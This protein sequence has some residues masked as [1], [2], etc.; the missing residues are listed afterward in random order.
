G[1][2][3]YVLV[4]EVF[5][6]LTSSET[7]HRGAPFYFYGETLA[8]A[9]GLW[10][11]VLAA[12]A[13]GLVRCWRRGGH[14][15]P[16]IALATRGTAA[17][18]VFFTPSASKRPHYILPAIVPLALLVAVAVDAERMRA[19]RVLRFLAWV[20]AVLGAGALVA[21]LRGAHGSGHFAVLSRPLLM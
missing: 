21:V 8:W 14:D 20:V 1:F 19:A 2:A 6:R 4:E 18:L 17:L 7:F 12:L 16:V 10:G 13:P 11:I 3:R 5:H 15:G 9:L